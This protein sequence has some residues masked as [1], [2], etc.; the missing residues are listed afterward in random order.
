MKCT[1]IQFI[2]KY[3]GILDV[4]E[5]KGIDSILFMHRGKLFQ[6]IPYEN[7]IYIHY[8]M[9]HP[10]VKIYSRWDFTYSCIINPSRTEIYFCHQNQNAQNIGNFTTLSKP[11]NIGTHLKGIETSFQV[12]PLFFKSFHVCVSHITF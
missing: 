3:K 6:Q 10:C 9:N 8:I 4:F 5:G 11:H 2:Y 7:E 1:E 12:V